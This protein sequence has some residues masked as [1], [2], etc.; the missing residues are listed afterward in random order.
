MQTLD[1]HKQ[2]LDIRPILDG[3]HNTMPGMGKI[4][5]KPRFWWDFFNAQFL[6]IFTRNIELS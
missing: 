4:N 1:L 6:S 2:I 5:T 3:Q